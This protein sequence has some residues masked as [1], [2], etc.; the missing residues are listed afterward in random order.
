MRRQSAEAR[1]RLL[2]RLARLIRRDADRLAELGVPRRRRLHPARAV[3][4]DRPHH[5]LELPAAHA[6]PDRRARAGGR[7]LLRAQ[8]RR[9]RPGNAVEVAR[10]A[11]EAGFPAG[12]FNV[13]PGLGTEA[14]AALAAHPGIDHVSF[15]GSRPVGASIATAAAANVVP[16]VLELANATEYGL[17]AACGRATSGARTG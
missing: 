4:R 15:T 6:R 5:A 1:S 9:G 10:L 17:V 14:G 16:V 11:H 7:Q 2:L 3:R 12:M 8:A 13:V